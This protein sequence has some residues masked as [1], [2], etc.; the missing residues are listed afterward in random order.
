MIVKYN[1]LKKI[2]EI[3]QN[4]V[5]SICTGTFDLF[6]Y[7][8]LMFLK[9][10]KNRSDILVVVIKSDKDVKSKGNNRPIINEKERALIVDS[11][12]YTDYTIISDQI[13]TTPLIQKI[14]QDESLNEKEQYRLMRDGSIF[15]KLKADYLYVTS[16]KPI[17]RGIK[18][19][20]Q[21]IGMKIKTIPVQGNDY[22]TSD[23]I[24]KIKKDL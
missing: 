8:H 2:R 20:S 21:Q 10:L 17:P 11:I 7:S 12:K 3:H 13:H 6:H 16:D 4:Q 18:E 5:I 23:I 15:E 24:D 1:Q 9:Y 14:I 19:F 22:H